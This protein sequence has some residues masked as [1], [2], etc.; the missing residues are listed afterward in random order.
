MPARRPF[1]IKLN[2]F[3]RWYR[4]KN[5]ASSDMP[6]HLRRGRLPGLSLTRMALMMWVS[7]CKAGQNLAAAM[8]DR[9]F[10]AQAAGQPLPLVAHLFVVPLEQ[11]LL[12]VGQREIDQGSPSGEI[13]L[14]G[15]AHH[16]I[17]W[18]PRGTLSPRLHPQLF[19]GHHLVVGPA[20][21]PAGHESFGAAQPAEDVV[22]DD[23]EMSALAADLPFH[24][25]KNKG[26]GLLHPG[27]GLTL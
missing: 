14:S 16:R 1:N 19:V 21:T 12:G 27:N 6:G 13:D 22:A 10:R 7:G 26:T 9:V 24:G 23:A 18:R 4:P 15:Q 20:D 3:L 11:D 17:G 2:L 25:I 5:R 8:G